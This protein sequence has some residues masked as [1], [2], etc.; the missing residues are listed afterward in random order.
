[1]GIRCLLVANSLAWALC[2]VGPCLS[3]HLGPRVDR[4]P[5]PPL[6]VPLLSP[7]GRSLCLSWA[8]RC[9]VREP[10]SLVHGQRRRGQCCLSF[11]LFRP[12]QGLCLCRPG[13]EW[14][15]SAQPQGGRWL[16]SGWVAGKG[17]GPPSAGALCGQLCCVGASSPALCSIKALW[18]QTAPLFSCWDCWEVGRPD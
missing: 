7:L 3:W 9:V 5:L 6:P 18:S 11:P 8:A 2:H 17:A 16:G 13:Q 15:S 10:H 1:M 4:S 12:F 14:V